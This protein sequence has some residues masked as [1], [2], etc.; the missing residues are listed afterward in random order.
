MRHGAEFHMNDRASADSTAVTSNS[1]VAERP[2][3]VTALN[4]VADTDLHVLK[5]AIDGVTLK[6]G[7]KQSNRLAAS[8][9]VRSDV[10]YHHRVCRCNHVI[11]K[12]TAEIDAGVRHKPVRKRTAAAYTQFIL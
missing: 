1:R 2:N 12:T 5:M 9:G 3:H 6:L 8:R 10:I 4:M 7:M 11:T